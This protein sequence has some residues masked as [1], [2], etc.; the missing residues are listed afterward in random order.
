MSNK[1]EDILCKYYDVNCLYGIYVCIELKMYVILEIFF[2]YFLNE[3]N[4]GKFI[5]V[6][7][8]E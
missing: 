7:N 6:Y 5:L 8:I 4:M 1:I 2:Q 3:I